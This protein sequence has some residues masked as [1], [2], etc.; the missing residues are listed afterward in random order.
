MSYTTEDAIIDLNEIPLE[1]DACIESYTT[2]DAVIDLNEIPAEAEEITP[3]T[4]P[5]GSKRARPTKPSKA[6]AANKVPKTSATSSP[7]SFLARRPVTRSMAKELQARYTADLEEAVDA[8]D[9][10]FTE[11]NMLGFF[12]ERQHGQ[13]AIRS[14]TVDILRHFAH[15]VPDLALVNKE[16]NNVF[17][18][19]RT[20]FLI[21]NQLHNYAPFTGHAAILATRGQ[22]KALASLFAHVPQEDLQVNFVNTW[23]TLCRITANTVQ[24]GAFPFRILYSLQ[25]QLQVSLADVNDFESL[26]DLIATVDNAPLMDFVLNVPVF[27]LADYTLTLNAFD[28]FLDEYRIDFNKH[29]T[30]AALLSFVLHLMNDPTLTIANDFFLVDILLGTIHFD[31]LLEQL[32]QD[33]RVNDFRGDLLHRLLETACFFNID[34]AYDLAVCR[35][36]E[37]SIPLNIPRV[38]LWLREV[39]KHKACACYSEL[40]RD[41]SN[42]S[43]SF[44]DPNTQQVF[45]SPLHRSALLG[46]LRI[47]EIAADLLL[48]H[49]NSSFLNAFLQVFGNDLNQAKFQKKVHKLAIKLAATRKSLKF[50][51][52]FVIQQ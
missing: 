29:N 2:E 14:E 17:L 18:A 1:E 28:A 42:V 38:A 24:E 16:F 47:D 22:S 10:H 8:Y 23:R 44:E 34:L 35:F 43:L 9:N 46:A 32:F 11:V 31:T 4:S 15:Y 51:K 30:P 33:P 37:W 40:C 5:V 12:L 48:I 19:S 20:K 50:A 6:K 49:E 26:L 7:R 25:Q 41:V 21:D 27:T 52:R 13:V 45:N 39:P 36:A 3:N